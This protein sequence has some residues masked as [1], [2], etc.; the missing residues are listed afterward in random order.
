MHRH[1]LHPVTTW[2]IGLLGLLLLLHPIHALPAGLSR[3]H[4]QSRAISLTDDPIISPSGQDVGSVL[5]SASDLDS[6][7]ANV[8]VSHQLSR[9]ARY[10]RQSGDSLAEKRT[11]GWLRARNGSEENYVSFVGGPGPVQL[12][13][14]HDP[15]A[16]SAPD[17]APT[18]SSSPPSSTS[19]A[20]APKSSGQ[21]K[22]KKVHKKSKKKHTK[23]KGRKDTVHVKAAKGEEGG[24]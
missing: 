4:P 20:T 17:S 11:T 1:F 19:S 2:L 12:P 5:P 14:V 9:R 8:D 21:A 16:A 22:T 10:L 3:Q 24:A 23:E 15:S 7:L 6:L 18:S 13:P